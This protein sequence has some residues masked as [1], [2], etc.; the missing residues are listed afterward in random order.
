MD[1]GGPYLTAAFFCERVIEDKEGILTAVR[2]VDRVV[3]TAIGVGTPE[4]MPATAVSLTLLVAFKSGQARGRHDVQ[5]V[6]ESPAGLRSQVAPAYSIL[7]EG[8]DR[9]ANL[10]L[11]LSFSAQQE[12]L[13]WFDVLLDG[14]RFTRVPLRLVYQRQE[15]GSLGPS[16]ESPR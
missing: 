15:T 12:G 5:V 3:Q 16:P 7:L 14:A 2:I 9:G 10:V 6:V 4:E 1:S 11:N 8:E 13:Y